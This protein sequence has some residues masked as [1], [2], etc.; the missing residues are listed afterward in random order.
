MLQCLNPGKALHRIDKILCVCVC[1]RPLHSTKYTPVYTLMYVWAHQPEA[2]KGVR[3]R[4]N[5]KG[6]N[7]KG[8]QKSNV[9]R[10]LK[11]ISNHTVELAISNRFERRIRQS[12]SLSPVHFR[13]EI[14][15]RSK[16]KLSL[17][18]AI[19]RKQKTEDR[20]HNPLVATARSLKLS[21]F[22]RL[23]R[24][25]DRCALHA[26]P[27][28]ISFSPREF[29][30]VVISQLPQQVSALLSPSSCRRSLS[31]APLS[32]SVGASDAPLLLGLEKRVG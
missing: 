9:R 21:T 16:K 15:V 28:Y 23:N 8:T 17:A 30:E 11:A 4:L 3:I 22:C 18:T 29:P 2:T 13:V 10:V 5:P 1:C 19:T 7:P 14:R 25:G 32:C 12:L 20:T 6:V 27:R 24:R 31:F 26:S